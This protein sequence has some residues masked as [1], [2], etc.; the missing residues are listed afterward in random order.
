MKPKISFE[1]GLRIGSV[2]GRGGTGSRGAEASAWRGKRRGEGNW[3]IIRVQSKSGGGGRER[4]RGKKKQKRGE[5]DW[6]HILVLSIC[7]TPGSGGFHARKQGL[8]GG[9]PKP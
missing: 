9:N 5:E 2:E 3:D 8:R 7:S 4:G 6:D 1:L